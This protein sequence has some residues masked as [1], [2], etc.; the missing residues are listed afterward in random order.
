[1]KLD[2]PRIILNVLYDLKMI[3][4]HTK[5]TQKGHQFNLV[6]CS[7][8]IESYRN[9]VRSIISRSSIFSF[10]KWNWRCHPYSIRQVWLSSLITRNLHLH[11]THLL[12]RKF[13][14]KFVTMSTFPM[15]QE[16]HC[17]VAKPS[18]REHDFVAD[19]VTV[20]CPIEKTTI[21]SVIYNANKE[22]PYA[23]KSLLLLRSVL[24]SS[25]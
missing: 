16:Q 12:T 18:K 7:F 9:L 3:L 17:R 10:S 8:L 1:M 24:N 5:K 6:K 14:T 19:S 2:R 22:P 23:S 21:C 11:H 25:V 15:V 4:R 13:D 20:S